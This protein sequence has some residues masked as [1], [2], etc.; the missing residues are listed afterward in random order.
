MSVLLQT[1]F[2]NSAEC[3]SSHIRDWSPNGSVGIWSSPPS[4]SVKC[5]NRRRRSNSRWTFRGRFGKYRTVSQSRTGRSLRRGSSPR[6]ANERPSTEDSIDRFQYSSYVVELQ[7]NSVRSTSDIE[8]GSLFLLVWTRM[9]WNHEASSRI[10]FLKCLSRILNLCFLA[11]L[12]QI[13]SPIITT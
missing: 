5:K 6:L 9:I 1:G 7:G 12:S 3:S 11:F 2:H 10:A 4:R 13:L 8:D